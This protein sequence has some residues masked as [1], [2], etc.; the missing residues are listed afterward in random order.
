MPFEHDTRGGLPHSF[1]H[2]ATGSWIN[3]EYLKAVGSN[4][5]WSK[6]LVNIQWLEILGGKNPCF[7]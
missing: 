6:L 7:D 3:F 2:D 5:I 1:F 4:P